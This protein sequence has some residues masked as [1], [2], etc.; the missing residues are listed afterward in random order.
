[1]K[2]PL[3]CI[4]LLVLIKSIELFS[5]FENKGIGPRNIALGNSTVAFFENLY[6]IYYNPAGIQHQKDMIFS[7]S[8]CTYYGLKDIDHNIF[9]GSFRYGELSISLSTSSYGN[10]LYNEWHIAAGI[11][12]TGLKNIKLG[13]SINKYQLSIQN[14]GSKSAL[15]LNLGMIFLV[16]EYLSIGAA[17]FNINRPQ[18]STENEIINSYISIG[19]SYCISQSLT[20]N[21]SVN[22][23][24]ILAEEYLFGLEYYLFKIMW[25]RFGAEINKKVFCTGIGLGR[26]YINIDYSLRWHPWL[27]NSHS[28][29]IAITL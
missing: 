20:L 29:S 1:M 5:A 21:T 2:N 16:Q 9:I 23:E 12:Y 11:A 8:N 22:K 7:Y 26:K 18:I 15:G 10:K 19:L 17:F 14:Y 3:C 25:I 27:G 24:S 6:A 28:I 13:M 4:V